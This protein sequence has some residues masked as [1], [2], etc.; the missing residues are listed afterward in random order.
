MLYEYAIERFL[1]REIEL[2]RARHKKVKRKEGRSKLQIAYIE[3]LSVVEIK[4]IL[5]R[6]GLIKSNLQ[7]INQPAN[8]EH[9]NDVV[10]RHQVL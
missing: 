9:K 7:L 6:P 10:G 3:G 4:K 2:L 1:A 8:Q 5:K